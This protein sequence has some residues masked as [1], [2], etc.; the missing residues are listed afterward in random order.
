[1][2]VASAEH[3]AVGLEFDHEAARVLGIHLTDQRAL[4]AL[5]FTGPMTATA[6]AVS[7]SL[8]AA[9]VTALGDRLV[10][11]KLVSRERD[12][13]D[14]RRV[15]LG[16]TSH[17]KA[18]VAS[19]WGPM[20]AAERAFLRDYSERELRTVLDFLHKGQALQA[21]QA[22][23]VRKLRKPGAARRATR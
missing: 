16:M 9:A 18:R 15:T 1:M 10:A 23:R 20:A 22:A 4:S 12:A 14:R 8:S 11:A 7:L 13:H 6:L 2:V 17:G 5:H 19:L 3:Q 21:S